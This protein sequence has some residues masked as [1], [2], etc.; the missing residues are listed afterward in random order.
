MLTLKMNSKR[1]NLL[2]FAAPALAECDGWVIKYVDLKK[3]S[4]K[5]LSFIA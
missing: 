4:S 3:M 1:R 2:F 5:K